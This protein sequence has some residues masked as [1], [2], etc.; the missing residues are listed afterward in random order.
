MSIISN[1][2]EEKY[3]NS[4]KEMAIQLKKSFENYINNHDFD[5]NGHEI[6]V[7]IIQRLKSYY[8]L[9]ESIKSL[10]QKRYAAPASDF[11]V[12]TILFYLKIFLSKKMPHLQVYSEKSISKKRN[13]IRPDIS[14]WHDD[15]VVSIIECK[16]QL[17]WDRSNW[18]KNFTE[19]EELLKSQFPSS[20][21]FLLV[22]TES[23]WEGFG[24]DTDLNVK[25]FSLLKD[26]VWP[27][28]FENVNQ[29]N[30]RFEILLEKLLEN[31]RLKI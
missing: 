29:I 24:S 16:T 30:C 2:I 5:L 26:K 15:K 28:D 14:I 19:R 7:S 27:S 1:Q 13:S 17:G 25:Y 23:N 10:L 18:S 22:M 4:F 3:L 20:Q 12:E 21:A 9:Q 11:F 6:T 8:E 31:N